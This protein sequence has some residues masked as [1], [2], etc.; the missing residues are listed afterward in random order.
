[1]INLDTVKLLGSCTK[2]SILHPSIHDLPNTINDLL[3]RVTR[4]VN[5][6]FLLSRMT[7]QLLWTE[8]L[9]T[10]KPASG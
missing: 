2:N 7:L 3:P 6:L 5:L 9:V 1:M 10:K 4:N 8:K